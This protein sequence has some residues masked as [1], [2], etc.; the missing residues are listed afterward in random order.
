[1]AVLTY[2]GQKG[3]RDPYHTKLKQTTVPPLS[4]WGSKP[5]KSKLIGPGHHA[6]NTYLGGEPKGI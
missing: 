6:R 4:S 3:D 2:L 1:M 5:P